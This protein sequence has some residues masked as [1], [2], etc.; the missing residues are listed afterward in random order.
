MLFKNNIIKSIMNPIKLLL[1]IL[2]FIL[3]ISISA[4]NVKQDNIV[5]SRIMIT[6]EAI[7]N[8]DF[9]TF[10]ILEES[11]ASRITS[12]N[13]YIEVFKDHPIFGVGINNSAKYF[14]T[15][16]QNGAPMTRENIYYFYNSTNKTGMHLCGAILYQLLAWTGII[17]TFLFYKFVYKLYKS[18]LYNEKRINNGIIKDYIC[19]L[20]NSLLIICFYFSFYDMG[21]ENTYTWFLFALGCV[22]VEL[23]KKDLILQSNIKENKNR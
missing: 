17:G 9:E 12:Y 19:G 16:F 22:I 8:K 20:R 21:L 6:I 2:I 13:A 23:I 15:I 14:I 3:I 4:I 11:L 1:S 18:I 5:Q 7:K 10:L